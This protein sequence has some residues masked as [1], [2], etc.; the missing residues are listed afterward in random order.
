MEAVTTTRPLR[1]LW[2][3]HIPVLMDNAGYVG[4]NWITA[5][6][7]ALPRQLELAICFH[8]AQA[9]EWKTRHD[10]TTIYNLYRKPSKWKR[11]IEKHRHVLTDEQTAEYLRVIADFQP[12]VIQIFG[13]ESGF[14]TIA[15]QTHVPVVIHVQGIL[16]SC[17]DHWFPP[18]FSLFD[19]FRY[20]SLSSLLLGNGYFH[21]YFLLKKQAARERKIIARNRYFFT[22]THWDGQQ[23]TEMNPSAH[24]IHC[25][26]LL[27]PA[28]FKN[29]WILPHRPT[30]DMRLVSVMNGELY[31]GLDNVLKIAAELRKKAELAFTWQI[32]GMDEFHPAKHLF[33]RKAGETF[34]ENRIHF[35]GQKS[36]GD[37]VAELLKNDVFV[38]VS[39]V[40]NSPNSVC[41]AMLLG[42]PVLCNDVGGCSSLM[43]HGH[44][45]MLLPDNAP[46][47]WAEELTRLHYRPE[48]LQSLGSYA[49][50]RALQRH[51]PETIS[52]TLLQTYELMMNE[53]PTES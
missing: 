13:T 46:E 51:N 42:M 41:E 33:E 8:S 34:R 45:G 6:K 18:G 26:E 25:D 7:D 16:N 28:F 43:T 49:R 12:D 48:E 20:A 3:S 1:V 30:H 11:L 24:L 52:G 19:T 27:R 10:P 36:A 9:S 22:R 14:G 50:A 44:D 40:D 2:F 47:Q 15:A 53:H 21:R 29:K 31:K 32:I 38:H 5:L 37:L 23:I 35:L 39:H 4:G 17:L